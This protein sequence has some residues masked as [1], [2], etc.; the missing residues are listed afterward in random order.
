MYDPS[1]PINPPRTVVRTWVVF[2][3][4]VGVGLCPSATFTIKASPIRMEIPTSPPARI[5]ATRS[6]AR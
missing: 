1:T 6:T 5:T 3:P 2:S 4:R